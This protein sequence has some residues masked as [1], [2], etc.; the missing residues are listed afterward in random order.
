MKKALICVGD[1]PLEGTV[2][3][4]LPADHADMNP[5]RLC[6]V[7]AGAPNYPFDIAPG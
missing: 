3:P 6:L 5:Y 1:A 4:P 2:I 7:M